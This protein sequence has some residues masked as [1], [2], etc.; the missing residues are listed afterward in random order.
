MTARKPLSEQ[1]SAD[2][3]RSQA[4]SGGDFSRGNG[5][6][7]STVFCVG[8]V[9]RSIARRQTSRLVHDCFGYPGERVKEVASGTDFG[10]VRVGLVATNVALYVYEVRAPHHVHRYAYDELVSV[11]EP[12]V[13]KK[14][15]VVFTFQTIPRSHEQRRL[16]FDSPHF[17]LGVTDSRGRLGAY[18]QK[19]ARAPRT[20]D[21]RDLVDLPVDTPVAPLAIENRA[22]LSPAPRFKHR[23]SASRATTDRRATVWR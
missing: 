9:K 13:D 23:Q 12:W 8:R 6:F 2:L 19:A 15:R 7:V 17:Y 22:D 1:R 11:E 14:G 16:G 20:P 5:R 21:P 3:A 10:E 18:L 4:R